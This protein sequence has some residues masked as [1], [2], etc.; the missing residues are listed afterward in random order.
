MEV[1]KML[2]NFI[3]DTYDNFSEIN[4]PEVAARADFA[5]H[6]EQSLK[7]MYFQ[8]LLCSTRKQLGAQGDD[9]GVQEVADHVRGHQRTWRKNKE[10]W[11]QG[12]IAFF[13]KRVDDL[14]IEDFL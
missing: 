11:Q 9:V 13:E 2:A 12:L 6:T 14:G 3:A 5:G 8:D 7:N 1:E 4:W 10:K